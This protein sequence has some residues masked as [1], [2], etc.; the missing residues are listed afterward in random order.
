MLRET[1]QEFFSIVKDA[2]GSVGDVKSRAELHAKTYARFRSKYDMASQLVVEA[3]SYAWS[4]RKAV[5][6]GEDV[7]RCVVRF[8]RRLFSFKQTRRGNPVLSLRLSNE[9]IGLPISRDGAYQ[10]LQK[11]LEEG[12][13]ATSI[14]MKRSLGFLIVL[15]KDFPEPSCRPNW[16]GI[17]VNSSK[18][19]VSIVCKEKV[20]KQTYYGQDVCVKQI[21]F[22]DRRTKL[23]SYRD[24]GS[25]KAGLKLKN[26]SGKQR[27]YVRTRVWQISGE[28]VKLAKEFNANIAIERLKHLRKRKGEWGKNSRK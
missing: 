20:L 3:A 8:D 24:R 2:L 6:A 17:D 18:I 23:Q 25:S 19:A 22:E 7:G 4:M 21:R 16:M 12:W 9:R 27:N 26:L 1:Y 5:D 15:S 28:I 10:R 14:I 11:H 13:L